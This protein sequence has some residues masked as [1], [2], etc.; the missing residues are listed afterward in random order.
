MAPVRVLTAVVAVTAVS[1][2]LLQPSDAAE[3]RS[4]ATQEPGDPVYDTGGSGVDKVGVPGTLLPEDL[5]DREA[6]V[7]DAK[8]WAE[9]D[10]IP[11]DVAIAR[12]LD[13]QALSEYLRDVA[14]TYAGDYAGS[15]FSDDDGILSV[16]FAQV[17]P[18]DVRKGLPSSL[19]VTRVEFVGET[20]F[21][22]A[23]AFEAQ[24]DVAR[25]LDELGGDYA[26]YYDAASATIVAQLPATSKDRVDSSALMAATDLPVPV[27]TIFEPGQISYAPQVARGGGR[28]R[29]SGGA[30]CTT[31]FSV[32]QTISIQPPADRPTMTTAGHCAAT[33]AHNGW[34]YANTGGSWF[35]MD[36]IAHGFGNGQ[37][38]ASVYTTTEEEV[39]RFYA[40]SQQHRAVTGDL[41][42]SNGQEI[43]FY[44]RASDFR[45]CV[46]VLN[47]N[48]SFSDGGLDFSH[49]VFMQNSPIATN[50]DSGG[51]WFKGNR[52]AGVHG[53]RLTFAGGSSRLIFTPI[54]R[55]SL[56]TAKLLSLLVAEP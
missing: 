25:K 48:G 20:G 46:D 41:N 6:L 37:G 3:P 4:I 7:V 2:T 34:E 30:T 42:I 29:H 8:A 36:Y 12:M 18:S 45:F 17:V 5:T 40:D 49:M 38:D 31:G 16:R 13:Q 15:W 50:G 43:C 55:L 39:P 56:T 53:G 27:R 52:A 51:P 28:M 1:F 23:Q 11:V 10:G 21:S 22:L 9:Q 32:L 47:A 33:V 14:E 24:A 19:S 35:G 54:D 26:L 44:G